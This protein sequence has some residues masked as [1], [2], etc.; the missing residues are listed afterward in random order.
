MKINPVLRIAQKDHL[1]PFDLAERVVLDNHD[2]DG[3]LIL[4]GGHK[5]AMS[6][7]NPPSPTNPTHCRPGY[8]IWAAMVYG[9]PGAIVARFPDKVCIWPRLAGTC[10]AHQV[11]IVPLSQL[12]I[13]SSRKRWPSSRATTCGF[14]GLSVRVARLSMALRQSR[15]P[16]CAAS[17][18]LRF[19]LRFKSGISSRNVLRLSPTSPASTG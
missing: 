8:A 19:S 1:L 18:K 11:A 14:M 16:A 13:A 9:S 6:M 3:E 15:M 2:L 10:R 4:H 12:T 5:S 17:R 7:E